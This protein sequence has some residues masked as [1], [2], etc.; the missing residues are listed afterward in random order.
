MVYRQIDIRVRLAS[1]DI[2]DVP[3]IGQ[4]HADNKKSHA[5]RRHSVCRDINDKPVD[6][7]RSRPF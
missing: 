5:R 4:H 1:A 7:A 6:I 3:A 2:C